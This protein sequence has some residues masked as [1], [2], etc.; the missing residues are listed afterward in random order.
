MTDD[1]RSTLQSWLK[2]VPSSR[3]E[4]SNEEIAVVIE[5]KDW[6][7]PMSNTFSSMPGVTYSERENPLYDLL[8]SKAK[9]LRGVPDGTLRGIFLGDAGCSLLRNICPISGGKEVTGHQIINR[10][11][12]N[13][14]IDMVG[15]FVPRRRN[16]NATW[17][18]ENPRLWHL[19]LYSQTLQEDQFERILAIRDELPNPHLHGYQARSWLRQGMTLPQARGHYLGM[20]LTG[21]I[22]KMKVHIS[23]RGLQ[24]FMAGRLNAEQLRNFIVGDHNPF[25]FNLAKGK[26]ITDVKFESTGINED[27]DYLVFEFDD[28]PAASPLEIPQDLKST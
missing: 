6:V 19:Y 28:D 10:F 8:K 3:L 15:V 17:H 26:M 11:L 9:Q 4:Y 25:E 18:H 13:N 12:Q 5:W 14:P 1:L 22:R 23:A 21:G 16:E 27:D 20:R 24:E 7:H 2:D